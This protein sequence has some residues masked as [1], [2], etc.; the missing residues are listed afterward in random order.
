MNKIIKRQRAL[1]EGEKI[2]IFKFMQNIEL[3]TNIYFL[4]N[5][6]PEKSSEGIFGLLLYHF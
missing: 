2:A 5:K 4:A 6:N 1:I 3:C